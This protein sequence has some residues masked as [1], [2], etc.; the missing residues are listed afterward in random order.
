MITNTMNNTLFAIMYHRMKIVLL[1]TGLHFLFW[2]FMTIIGITFMTN[3]SNITYFAI[4]IRIIS[5]CLFEL[6]HSIFY[7]GIIA[8]KTIMPYELSIVTKS[9]LVIA[10]KKTGDGV[11]ENGKGICYEYT[12]LNYDD[13]EMVF[14]AYI[15]N[16]I[17]SIYAS[18][19]LHPMMTLQIITTGQIVLDTILQTIR[20]IVLHITKRSH[21]KFV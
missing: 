9:K 11:L 12:Y 21:N 2:R 6:F 7:V 18:Y 10:H 19:Y 17:I 14:Y 5:V 3:N 8:N 20:H 13:A 4:L 15:L 16:I 1:I